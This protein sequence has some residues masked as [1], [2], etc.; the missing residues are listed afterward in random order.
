MRPGVTTPSPTS[1]TL[2]AWPGRRGSAGAQDRASTPFSLPDEPARAAAQAR[3]P[4]PSRRKDAGDAAVDR[5]EAASRSDEDRRTSRA[6][7]RAHPAPARKADSRRADGTHKAHSAR[8]DHHET[9]SGDDAAATEEPG[10][11]S[12]VT[13]DGP[14][15]GAV[16]SQA[17][18]APVDP[19]GK[20]PSDEGKSDAE[21]S[22]EGSDVDDAEGTADAA[23]ALAALMPTAEPGAAKTDGTADAEPSE[24][25]VVS[26]AASLPKDVA[27]FADPTDA[28]AQPTAGAP[29]AKVG[30]AAVTDG[31]GIDPRASK[32]E[33][34]PGEPAPEHEK[35]A[36]RHLE[37]PAPAPEFKADA[38]SIN[39][40]PPAHPAA[41]AGATGQAGQTGQAAQANPVAQPQTVPV[42]NQVPLGAV[43]IEIGL[44]SL[45]GM[46]RFEIRLDPAELGRID[47]RLD[48][49]D[50]GDVKAHLVVDRVETL[51]L[52]QRDA[53]TLER[54]FEQ[55]GLK[56]TEGSIDLSLRD[57]GSDRR[58][59][60]QGGNEQGRRAPAKRD[61]TAAVERVEAIQQPRRMMWRGAGGVD[62]RI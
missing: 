26:A 39:P 20:G 1:E 22:G 29:Q 4:S 38:A 11:D 45:S 52:L 50:G 41:Q 15:D 40:A 31:T 27:V 8:D 25:P 36:H 16:L 47:V 56:P 12:A 6:E 24:G 59:T 32:P 48:I 37:S 5:R 62:L 23:T 17:D 3:Q 49:G 51:A 54:A 2:P 57:P 19:D 13:S 33:A 60:D 14:Q 46:N 42:L 53:K 34:G 35:T 21:D 28:A 44:K 7:S 55:A 43:P 9:S 61:D 10:A 18:G 58:G 30:D